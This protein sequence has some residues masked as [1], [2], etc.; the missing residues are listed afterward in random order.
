MQTVAVFVHVLAEQKLR[1]IMNTY[2]YEKESINMYTLDN[3]NNLFGT[4]DKGL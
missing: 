2:H 4:G 1:H 3:D